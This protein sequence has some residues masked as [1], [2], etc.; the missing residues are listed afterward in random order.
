MARS[1]HNNSM[2]AKNWWCFVTTTAGPCCYLSIRHPPIGANVWVASLP[3]VIRMAEEETEIQTENKNCS[4]DCRAGKWILFILLGTFCVLLA[5]RAPLPALQMGTVSDWG[6]C[7][8]L[9]HRIS[10]MWAEVERERELSCGVK[11]ED[12][13]SPIHFMEELDCTQSPLPSLSSAI[14]FGGSRK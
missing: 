9:P 12:P 1:S 14:S 10:F 11:Q 6:T 4:K 13:L 3:M 5:P 8:R 7:S 2:C